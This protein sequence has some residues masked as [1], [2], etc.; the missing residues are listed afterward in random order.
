MLYRVTG[1]LEPTELERQ[2]GGTDKVILDT[3]Q[4]VAE[5]QFTA[6][7]IAT[8]QHLAKDGATLPEDMG[9]AKFIIEEV[10]GSKS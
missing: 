4:V 6:I 8:R 3:Q 7:A 9:R 1:I 10:G 5:R 2:A